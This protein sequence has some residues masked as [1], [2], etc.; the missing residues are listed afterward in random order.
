MCHPTPQDI[1]GTFPNYNAFA[2]AEQ[3][4]KAWN[5]CVKLVFDVPRSTFTYLVEG[6]LAKEHRSLRNQVLSRYPGFFQNLI[7][8][9][10]KEIRLLAN[11]VSRDPQSTT[12][13]NIK[14]IERLTE[15]SPWDY[16]GQ[17]IKQQL[18][19]QEVPDNQQWRLGFLTKLYHMR[20]ERHIC[21]EDHTRISAWLDSL[22]S[23]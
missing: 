2:D 1:F 14:Y 23:T 6:Y 3:F 19:V 20:E 15:L 22:C 9:P 4:F 21:A 12:C 16:S 18:P 11:I 10:S 7:S 8:S 17:R 13:R 5:T